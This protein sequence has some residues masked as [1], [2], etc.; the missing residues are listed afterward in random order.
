MAILFASSAVAQTQV[1]VDENFNGY[2]DRAAFLAQWVPSVGNGTSALPSTDPSYLAGLLTDDAEF[3]SAI[4]D[5]Q[6]KAVDH[7]GAVA[8]APGQVNQWGGAFDPVLGQTADFTAVPSATQNVFLKADIF[9]GTSGNERMT[10]GL[11]FTGP[12]GSDADTI[13]DS[14]NIFEMG[15]W[16]ANPT[17]LGIPNTEQQSA[18]YAFRIINFGAVNIPADP[19]PIT[20]QPNWQFFKLDPA[21]DRT[22]D[23]DTI[24]NIGDIGAGWHTYSAEFSP[25][26]ITLKLDL[27][28]DGFKNLRDEGGTIVVGSGEAG[29]DAELTLPVTTLANGFNNLRVG[30]PSGNSSAGT[31]LMG[32][33]NILLQLQA[34]DIEP[35]GDD[36]DFDGDG[37][38]D[39]AD[40]ITWQRGVGMTPADLV[41]GDANDDDVVDGADLDVWEMQ[42]GQPAPPVS[43]I[44]EPAS[45]A[46]LGIA[47][48][49]GLAVARR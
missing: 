23:T 24:V 8:S 43:A 49:A 11:R 30:G 45:L 31:G 26:E 5:V 17:V 36:A 9:V 1:I 21:L 41:D 13:A 33:D 4:P 40:F 19:N 20:A 15:E 29:V 39:G 42:F 28:R 35:P 7:V 18:G 3:P 22:T 16:N 34:P 38:V 46:L 2:A 27:F 32:F 47:A 37:D 48:L 44:P 14:L 12:D 25:T 10:V 6:G